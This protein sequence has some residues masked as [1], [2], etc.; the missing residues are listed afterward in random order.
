MKNK[1]YIAVKY[2]CIAVYI[3]IHEESHKYYLIKHRKHG[4]FQTCSRLGDRAKPFSLDKEYVFHCRRHARI[5][6]QRLK[7]RVAS[8][9]N[10]PKVITAERMEIECCAQR[11][12]NSND[13]QERYTYTYK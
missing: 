1:K 13:P 2:Y 11:V 3:T 4:H 9:L 5:V 10:V 12:V 6:M 8:R 7:R